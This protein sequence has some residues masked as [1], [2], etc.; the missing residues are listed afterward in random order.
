M[1]SDQSECV[2]RPH[3]PRPHKSKRRLPSTTGMRQ[4]GRAAVT[5]AAAAAS[6]SASASHTSD[7][8]TTGAGGRRKR[9]T[10][11]SSFASSSEDDEVR[12]TPDYTSCGEEMESESISEKGKM[13]PLRHSHSHPIPK[14]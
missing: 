6:A 9:G 11:G 2:Q 7:G 12:S 8:A 13:I 3:P 1:S 5:V 10:G 14:S 4:T